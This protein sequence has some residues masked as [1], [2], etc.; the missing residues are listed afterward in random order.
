V[1][2]ILLDVGFQHLVGHAELLGFTEELFFF[3]IKAVGAVQVADGADRF[4]H[5]MEGRNIGT[6]KGRCGTRH[7]KLPLSSM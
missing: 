6:G 7:L 4:G 2:D 5:H 1:R 3:Q